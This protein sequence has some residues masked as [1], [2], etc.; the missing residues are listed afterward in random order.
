MSAWRGAVRPGDAGA[1]HYLL[2]FGEVF[3][4]VLFGLIFPALTW[5]TGLAAVGLF[6]RPTSIVQRTATASVLSSS[7]A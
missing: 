4:A 3:G 1:D 7:N 5:L 2:G 6:W